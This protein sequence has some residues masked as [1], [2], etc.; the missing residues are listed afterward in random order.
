MKQP[1]A[2][3]VA[4]FNGHSVYVKRTAEITIK[5]KTKQE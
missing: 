3:H 2:A 5:H 4:V 1:T